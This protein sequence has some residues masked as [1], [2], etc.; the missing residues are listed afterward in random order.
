MRALAPRLDRPDRVPE[1]TPAVGA[2]RGV[3]GMLL[4]CVQREF[5]PGV[6][7]ATARVLAAEGYDVV[8]PAGQGCCGAL[9]AHT[10]REPEARRFARRLIASFE[11]AGVQQVVVNSAGCGSA[12]KEYA[13]LL[14]DDPA[15]ADRAAAFVPRVIDVTEFLAGITPVAPRHRLALTVAYHDACHLSHAQGVR[16][17]PRTLLHGVPGLA[18]RE[19]DEPDLCCGSAG[20]YNILQPEPAGELGERKAGNVLATGADLL[21]TGNPGCLMQ[22]ASSARRLGHSVRTAHTI[23]LLDAAIRGL[24]ADQVGH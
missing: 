6:N 12:M 9:S 23:E 10:G 2:R 18:V 1:R 8:A 17:Q 3:V 22:I 16:T 14:A 19:I 13:D 7:A 24:P 15:W 4:G 20:V 5:F 21:V 11:R